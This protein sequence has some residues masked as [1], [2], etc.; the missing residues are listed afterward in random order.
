MQGILYATA[1]YQYYSRDA[2][3]L[4]NYGLLSAAVADVV[5]YERAE[6]RK[7]MHEEKLSLNFSKCS[8]L[9]EREKKVLHKLQAP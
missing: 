9:K 7:A 8:M 1:P 3:F 2:N 4:I 5:C 6:G